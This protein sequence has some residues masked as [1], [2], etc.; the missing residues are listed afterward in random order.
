M[1]TILL[2][3]FPAETQRV[4]NA[5]MRGARLCA[6]VYSVTEIILPRAS[7]ANSRLC[8]APSARRRLVAVC[9]RRRQAMGGQLSSAYVLDAFDSYR[10]CT[11]DNRF[12]DVVERGWRYYRDN[13]FVDDRIPKNSP[14][15]FI[16][17][18]PTACAQSLLTLRRFGGVQTASR[19]VD[20]TVQQMQCPDG[21]FGYQVRRR[22]GVRIPCMRWSSAQ[23]MYAGLSSFAYA[24]TDQV[25]GV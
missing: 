15:S 18:T 20:W 23:Y 17:S 21:H 14:T 6:Q 11:G 4:L 12:R 8:R 24:L 22:R 7:H 19:V 10:H 5:T 16:R 13:F 25:Q 1:V 2:G 3:Y 9:R